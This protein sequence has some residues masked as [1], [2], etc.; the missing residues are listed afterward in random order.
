MKPSG[1]LGL[2]PSGKDGLGG[3]VFNAGDSMICVVGGWF[4]WAT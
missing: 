3:W 4:G 1:A 2:K